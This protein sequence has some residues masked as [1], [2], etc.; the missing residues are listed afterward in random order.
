MATL[1]DR[2]KEYEAATDTR[3]PKRLPVMLRLD[4]KAFHTWTRGLEK[5]FDTRLVNAMAEL[6][7]YL[8]QNIAT[9]QIGYVQS[10]EITILLHSYKRLESE[11]LFD[12]RIQKIVSVAAST[13]S[14]YFNH[15]HGIEE[16]KNTLAIFD[17]R[18]FVL[19]ESEVC[20][21]LIWRQQ[22]ATRNSIQG[23]GQAHFSHKQ[24]Q[25]K[26]CPQIQDMLMLEKGI[27]WND[28]PTHLKRGSCAIKDTEG[29]WKVD[30]EIPIFT[31]DREYV[32]RHLVI[33][34]D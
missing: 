27:N 12:N 11:P 13:A 25:G 31:Q 22:D 30:L 10:D 1:G 9:A 5:P 7:R 24:L 14:A 26:K 34:R 18:I 20:N 23:L 15:I 3:L 19:P 32:N 16:K 4:G 6:T 8:C 28:L 29:K 21:A 33:E 2:M 17:C